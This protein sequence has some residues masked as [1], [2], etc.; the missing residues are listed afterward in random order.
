[1]LTRTWLPAALIIGLSIVMCPSAHAAD[2]DKKKVVCAPGTE[3]YGAP[4][5]HGANIWCR[6]PMPDGTFIRQGMY[7]SYN[8]SGK[9][10]VQ[11]AY[12]NNKPH[13]VWE[14]YDRDGHKVATTVY[15][16]GTPTQRYRYDENGKP[17]DLSRVEDVH[18][19]RDEARKKQRELNDWRHGKT[20][21][22]RSWAADSH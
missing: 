8:R 7:A 11:G 9:V 12:Y 20:Y 15:Y 21:I 19:K 18:K 14:K 22:P 2:K 16:D 17:V 6:Q 13:G 1:M 3:M 4:P 10:R 5:P